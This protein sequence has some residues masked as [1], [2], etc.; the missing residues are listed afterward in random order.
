MEVESP[1]EESELPPLMKSAYAPTDRTAGRSTAP[2]SPSIY[3]S[4]CGTRYPRTDPE[5]PACG[6]S[7]EELLDPRLREQRQRLAVRSTVSG[8]LPIAGAILLLLGIAFFVIGPIVYESVPRRQRWI[9]EVAI[10]IGCIAGGIAELASIICTIV[11]LYQAW[12]FVSRGDE[13]YSPG[14][15]VGLLFVPVFNLYWM[16]RAIPGLSTVLQAELRY[17]A[18]HRA[19]NAAGWGPGLIACILMLIPYLQ[20]FA[21]CMFLAWMLLANNALQRLVRYHE[22]VDNDELDNP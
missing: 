12:R 8:T 4:E 9:G 15:M 14:L 2:A 21:L 3:C 1:K 5:C 16:F 6:F 19:H 10:A 17:R 13:E 22:A 11:W 18:P 7:P 20:P